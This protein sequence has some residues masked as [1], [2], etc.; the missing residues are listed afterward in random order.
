[1]TGRQYYEPNNAEPEDVVMFAMGHLISEG[2][3]RHT[4]GLLETYQFP[5]NYFSMSEV[6]QEFPSFALKFGEKFGELQSMYP[7]L[8]VFS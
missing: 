1:M 7:T 8:I 4:E 2:V 3:P 5:V 6:D